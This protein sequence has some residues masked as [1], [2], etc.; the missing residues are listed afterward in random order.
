MGREA[1]LGRP[2]HEGPRRAVVAV[3]FIVGGTG[4]AVAR[5]PAGGRS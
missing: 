3:E 1:V 5:R 2:A 4:M